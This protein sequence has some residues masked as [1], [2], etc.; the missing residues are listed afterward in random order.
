MNCILPSGLRGVV[1]KLTGSEIN[2]F[3]NRDVVKSGDLFDR[4]LRSCWV[5]TTDSGPYSFAET[6]KSSPDWKRVLVADR[7]MALIAIRIA[8]YGSS[9]VFNVQCLNSQS[10]GERFE[11]EID[12][13]SDLDVFDLPES[14][15]DK[16][17]DDDNRFLCSVDGHEIVFKLTDGAGETLAGRRL[18][19]NRND[20]MSVGLASKIVSVDDK[21]LNHVRAEE[22]VKALGADSQLEL[23]QRFEEVDGG[24]ETMIE[25]ECPS[26]YTK[27]DKSLPLGEEGFWIPSS[28]K[29]R[30]KIRETTR[31]TQKRKMFQDPNNQGNE[32]D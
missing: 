17:R 22:F 24:V 20:I 31:K 3:T 25:I 15:I 19:K 32:E 30:K 16:I 26:C 8:T 29:Q 10:C 12:L 28:R 6:G 18:A 14:S 1:R 23:L 11:W 5:E 9:Y 27:Q 2:L 21:E 13:S 7:T 4:I